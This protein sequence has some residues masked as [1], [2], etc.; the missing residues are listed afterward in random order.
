[1]VNIKQQIQ[2]VSNERCPFY[3]ARIGTMEFKPGEIISEVKFRTD[4]KTKKSK[5]FGVFF[6]FWIKTKSINIEGASCGFCLN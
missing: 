1:M 4:F 6:T 2:L 3:W 5:K